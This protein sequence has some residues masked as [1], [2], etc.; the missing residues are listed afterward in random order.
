MKGI[1]PVI[2]SILLAGAV[3][4]FMMYIA[5]SFNDIINLIT[6]DKVKNSL[7]IDANKVAYA[8]IY[9]H[10]EGGQTGTTT[11]K[12]DLAD[13]PEEI[14][15]DEGIRARSGSRQV[16]VTLHGLEDEVNVSGRIINTKGFTP[17]VKYEDGVVYLGVE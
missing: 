17:Y 7:E 15:F 6:E 2:E 1:S 11:M 13:I 8:V 16:L 12:L 3:I 4:M 10:T 14:W 5:S 9:A